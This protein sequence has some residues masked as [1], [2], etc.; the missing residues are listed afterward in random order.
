MM[1]DIQ[2]TELLPQ[3]HTVA[4]SGTSLILFFDFSLPLQAV[5]STSVYEVG[6]AWGWEGIQ[7][8]G[9]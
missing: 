9:L 5:P 2:S 3:S 6:P 8:P 7:R 1:P 4:Y